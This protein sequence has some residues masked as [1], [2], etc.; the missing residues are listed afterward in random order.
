MRR[1]RLAAL[2]ATALLGLGSAACGAA[3]D[4]AVAPSATATP[5]AAQ[6]AAAQTAAATGTWTVSDT[7]KATVSV[8][9]QLAAFSFPSDAVLVAKGAKGSFQLNDNG[10]FST[11]SKITFDV[12]SLTSDS[13]QRDGFVKQTVL[14]TRQFPTATF[15]P[16]KVSGLALPLPASGTFTF[17]LAGKLTIHGVDKDATFDVTATRT[18]GDLRAT[19]TLAPTITFGDFGMPLPAAPGR[20]LSVVDEIKLVIE[21]VA[22]GPLR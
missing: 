12:A 15:V 16:T 11:D 2:F 5:A 7:S 4:V 8:R 9:E 3:A 21:V 10:T 18:G 6:T 1:R 22:T 19:A 20:V 13:P 14:A 17:T